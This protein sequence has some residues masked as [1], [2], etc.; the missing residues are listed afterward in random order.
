MTTAHVLDCCS[1]EGA[2][3]PMHVYRG[4]ASDSALDDTMQ[5][6]QTP[7][8]P[9]GRY[10]D[11]PGRG[12]TFYRE[13][14]GPEGAPTLLLLHGW[15]ASADLNFHPFFEA[16]GQHF[17]VIAPDHRGHGR[18]IRTDEKFALEDVADDVAEL[19][20]TLDLGHVL[21]VGYSMGGAVAQL[22]WKRHPH[23]VDGMVLAATSSTFSDGIKDTAMFGLLTGV[24]FAGR[25]L[26]PH[27]QRKFAL[28]LLNNRRRELD[29]WVIGEIEQHDWAR[30]GEAGIA[31]GK[32]DSREWL[33]KVD[34]PT[35]V[36]VTRH[37]DV[38]DPLR[39]LRMARVIPGAELSVVD[40]NHAVCAEDPERFASV[41]LA[42]CRKVAD[43]AETRSKL[44]PRRVS[45]RTHVEPDLVGLRDADL[46]GLVA[47]SGQD[48][49]LAGF[50]IWRLAPAEA[51]VG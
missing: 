2:I 31:I 24:Q 37:D 32:F 16:L 7:T 51:A 33:P 5:T 47:E 26:P 38:V 13:V 49:N 46:P 41:F 3:A 30:V 39:Q 43:R 11:L 12:R 22:L 9:P 18:G 48:R 34:V 29:E 6:H 19:C 28:R 50:T 1:S 25:R 35:S 45:R 36:I 42:A 14:K 8:L 17:R 27:L 4:V 20:A 23:L 21:V 40:G 10:I 44:M 15:T